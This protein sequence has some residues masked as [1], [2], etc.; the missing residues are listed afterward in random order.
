MKNQETWVGAELAAAKGNRAGQRGRQLCAASGQ[1]GGQGHH[2]VDG[3]EFAIERNG[4]RTGACGIAQR[5]I[6]DL[7]RLID[8]DPDDPDTVEIHD[9]MIA[10]LKGKATLRERARRRGR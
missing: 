9:M 10:L 4:T 5:A 7:Q 2:G 1:D 8:A 3:A 6:D